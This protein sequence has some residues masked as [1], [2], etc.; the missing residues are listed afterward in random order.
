MNCDERLQIARFARNLDLIIIEDAVNRM[1]CSKDYPALFSLAPNNTIYIFSTSKFLS[2]GLSV[3]YMIIP[4][5][6]ITLINTALYNMNLMVSPL[7]I[8]IVN[9]ILN[10]G[11]L[12]DLIVKKKKELI[13][14]DILI[15]KYYDK[16]IIQGEATCNFR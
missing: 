5:R 9:R 3:A 4:D 1:F 11:L 2:P 16:T 7:N 12:K 8:E 10:S 13:E 15:R 14:R 6:Y